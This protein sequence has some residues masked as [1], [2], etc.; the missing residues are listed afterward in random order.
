MYDCGCARQGTS[1][2]PA[3][4]C[5]SPS[6]YDCCTEITSHGTHQLERHRGSSGRDSPALEA[7]LMQQVGPEQNDRRPFGTAALHLC[8][9]LV[10]QALACPVCRGRASAQRGGGAAPEGA[11]G[12]PA[13]R[14]CGHDIPPADPG[15]VPA[16]CRRPAGRPRRPTERGGAGGCSA[17]GRGAPAPAAKCGRCR[18]WRGPGGLDRAAG[19]GLRTG[20]GEGWLSCPAGLQVAGHTRQAMAQ[21]QAGISTRADSASRSQAMAVDSTSS[22]LP[23]G[24]DAE[25][26]PH[27]SHMVSSCTCCGEA[28]AVDFC[29]CGASQQLRTS[30]TTTCSPQMRSGG[31]LLGVDC[32]SRGVAWVGRA[33]EVWL[34]GAG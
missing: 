3:H 13:C 15:R 24:L 10:C 17:S 6:Q 22:T 14:G 1:C 29:M 32:A 4:P 30:V 2:G 23:G 9:F 21:Q 18:L 5:C 19:A 16:A 12:R 28:S 25:S 33:A 27:R 8:Y 20:S 34:Q 11:G 26:G 31:H 7:E